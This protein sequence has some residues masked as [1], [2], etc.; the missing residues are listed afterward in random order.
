MKKW[1][2]G[3]VEKKHKNGRQEEIGKWIIFNP[4]MMHPMSEVLE[5]WTIVFISG[6]RSKYALIRKSFNFD[7]RLNKSTLK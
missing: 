4:I 6:Q 1:N 2:K 3:L 5:H 7:Y